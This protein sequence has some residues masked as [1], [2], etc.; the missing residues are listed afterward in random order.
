[1]VNSWNQRPLSILRKLFG[2][3]TCCQ[4]IAG[5]AGLLRSMAHTS[6]PVLSWGCPA[7][8]TERRS[9]VLLQDEPDQPGSWVGGGLIVSGSLDGV[10][11]AMLTQPSHRRSQGFVVKLFNMLLLTR[12][13]PYRRALA[14]CC[15]D[16]APRKQDQLAHLAA[17]PEGYWGLRTWS[18]GDGR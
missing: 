9:R 10:D 2:R 5:H 12:P 6:R 3:R 18:A 1:M 7:W 17:T 15:P 4:R 8:T 11:M 14:P 13:I 16:R